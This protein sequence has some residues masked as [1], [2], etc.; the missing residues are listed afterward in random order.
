M[1]DHDFETRALHFRGGFGGIEYGSTVHGITH[2][3][4]RPITAAAHFIATKS[5]GTAG[6]VVQGYA[7]VFNKCYGHKGRVEA[8]G[9]GCFARSL[10]GPAA[11]RFLASHDETELIATT[12]DRLELRQDDYGLAFRC[13]L[14]ASALGEN[15]ARLVAAGEMGG[16]SVGYEPL[17]VET[18]TFD[19]VEVHVVRD[20]RLFEISLV[21]KGAVSEAFASLADD[22]KGR[23]LDHELK[24]GALR[25]EA[26]YVGLRRALGAIATR[27][28]A[29]V[30]ARR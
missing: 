9:K 1:R 28:G 17:A 22:A 16:M 29:A 20:T 13:R 27:V 4:G 30:G 23:A 5:A 12:A 21:K 11:I 18:K 24:T 2:F 14:P 6:A 19:G 15:V 26:A 8:F 7:C 3:E 25:C 10:I